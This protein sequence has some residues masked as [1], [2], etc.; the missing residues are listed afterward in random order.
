MTVFDQ[1]PPITTQGSP[2]VNYPTDEDFEAARSEP[3]SPLKG[4]KGTQSFSAGMLINDRVGL[5]R[6]VESWLREAEANVG[7]SDIRGVLIALEDLG[8]FAAKFDEGYDVG[9]ADGRVENIGGAASA[10]LDKDPGV[11]LPP[12]DAH[13]EKLA[14]VVMARGEKALDPCERPGHGPL[15]ARYAEAGIDESLYTRISIGPI[16]GSPV[17]PGVYQHFKGTNYYVFG[18]A[19][20]TETDELLVIYK[21]GDGE[22]FARPL[23]NF[24][25]T[26]R[27]PGPG[28]KVGESTVVKRFKKI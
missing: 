14:N 28:K 16:K 8:A 3:T 7:I 18:T 26:L 25:G 15:V 4:R 11:P 17:E 19:K 13:H 9:R 24:L 1:D 2:P 12:L 27:R 20:H 22:H 6:E 10:I 5:A 21:N 23:D